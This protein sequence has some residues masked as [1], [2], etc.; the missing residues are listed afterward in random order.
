MNP[1]RLSAFGLLSICLYGI[2]VSDLPGADPLKPKSPVKTKTVKVED[3]TLTV[4]ATW[5][6]TPVTSKLRKAQFRIPAIKGDRETPELVIYYFGGGGGSLESNLRRW[7]SEFQSRGLKMKITTGKSSQGDYAI[8]DLRGTHLGPSFKRRKTPLKDARML[9]V[10]LFVKKKGYYYLKVSGP[11]KTID[12]IAE[13]LRTAF[14]GNAKTE[15]KFQPEP[16]G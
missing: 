2:A 4:P 8:A 7:I 12:S 10:M 14:G 3:I 6:Q 16:P 5:K 15:K 13:S 9:S 11:Q 1:L